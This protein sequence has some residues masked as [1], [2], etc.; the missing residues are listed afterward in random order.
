MQ[1]QGET[2]VTSTPA[3]CAGHAR[4]YARVIAM[5]GDASTYTVPVKATHPDHQM[6]G[7]A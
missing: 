5:L 6:R 7:V 4:A 1:H 2:L 3:S